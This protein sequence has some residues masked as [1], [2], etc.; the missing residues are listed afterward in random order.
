MSGK[1]Q[2]RQALRDPEAGALLKELREGRGLTREAL[3]H[4]MLLAK[5]P[6][7]NIPSIKT[8]WRVEEVGAVPSV[9]Y[10]FGL[11]QF[12]GRDLKEIWQP[13][14]TRSGAIAA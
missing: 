7:E 5:V 9:R 13:R 4:A 12:H 6:R 14:P 11:A 1:R 2:A 8:I 3:P 10:R